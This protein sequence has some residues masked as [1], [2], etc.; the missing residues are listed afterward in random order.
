MKSGGIGAVDIGCDYWYLRSW[1]LISR[2]TVKTK[3]VNGFET[4]L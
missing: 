3:L 1:L 2:A 4:V